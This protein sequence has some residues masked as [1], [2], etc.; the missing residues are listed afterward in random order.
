ML[1][2]M[3]NKSEILWKET[4]GNGLS[5]YPSVGEIVY[6]RKD[7]GTGMKEY[8]YK[9]VQVFNYPQDDNIVCYAEEDI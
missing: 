4:V 5:L 1:T 6:L 9:V 8:R 2:I 3:N 7:L